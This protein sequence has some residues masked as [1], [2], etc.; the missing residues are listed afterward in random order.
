M[1]QTA[2]AE[3]WIDERADGDGRVRLE[4]V[5]ELDIAGATRL[6]ERLR[7]LAE[8]GDPLVLDLHRLQFIDSS[9]LRV[10]V[11]AITDA[12]RDNRTLVFEGTPSPQVRQIIDLLELRDLF[13][14]PAP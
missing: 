6:E 3:F 7:A 14:P 5:G 8:G 10:L 9:G 4:L 11:G 1:E 2:D 13:W 12:R